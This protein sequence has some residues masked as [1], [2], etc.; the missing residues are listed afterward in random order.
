MQHAHHPS[1]SLALA[2]VAALSLGGWPAPLA[3]GAEAPA[4][5]G[6]FRAI[7]RTERLAEVGHGTLRWFGLPMYRA[8]LWSADGRYGA[9]P[10]GP[11]ALTLAYQ[12]GFSRTQ[13]IDI[14][15]NEWA[16]LELAD[17][18][19][20]ERWSHELEAIWTDVTDGDELSVLVT[21]TA[22][23]RFYASDRLLG[24]IEDPAFGPAYLAIWLDP[25][26]RVG[27]LRAE[28]LG[29]GEGARR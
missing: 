19:A 5:R 13:L 3:R 2:S 14:T 1:W 22:A 9:T 11:L 12:H 23:T 25:R 26:S 7:A 18:A 10:A 28:L 20:R 15:A 29:S 27:R 16:R 17:A 21:P 24:R 8:T 6:D 4:G